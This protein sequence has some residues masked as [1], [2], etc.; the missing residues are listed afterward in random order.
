MI[1]CT[2][3]QV[4]SW[5]QVASVRGVDRSSI[6]CDTR[7]FS[8]F[9]PLPRPVFLRLAN[10]PPGVRRRPGAGLVALAAGFDE[11]H[12]VCHGRPRWGACGPPEAVPSGAL[13]PGF[14]GGSATCQRA[15][16]CCVD[17][18]EPECAATH[19]I[20]RPAQRGG[21]PIRASRSRRCCGDPVVC[22]VGGRS[23]TF[24]PLCALSLTPPR[25]G[26][27]VAPVWTAW[28]SPRGEG[29]RPHPRARHQ[30]SGGGGHG[31]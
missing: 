23:V 17:P 30:R 7:P 26:L 11:D 4:K 10:Q 15:A 25:I 31:S 20:R 8:P 21:R 6:R 1:L 12:G 3:C 5:A 29:S 2:V 14:P 19:R 24:V 9:R 27:S 28:G 18:R 13:T 16:V 22:L